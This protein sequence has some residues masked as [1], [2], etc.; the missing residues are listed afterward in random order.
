MENYIRN[1][2]VSH[3]E[4]HSIEIDDKDILSI[5]DQTKKGVYAF[6]IIYV[7]NP[8]FMN[9]ETEIRLDW[10]IN[11]NLPTYK[12]KLLKLLN[13]SNVL[14]NKEYDVWSYDGGKTFKYSNSETLIFDLRVIRELKLN[15]IL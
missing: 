2:I 5:I 7:D 4:K 11:S 1:Q 13:R 14:Y 15:Q 10:V 12:F 3:F 8:D 6:Q 9:Q